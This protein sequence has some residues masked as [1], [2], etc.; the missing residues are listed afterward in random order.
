MRDLKSF[1]LNGTCGFDPHPGHHHFSFPVARLAG[2]DDCGPRTASS[3]HLHNFGSLRFVL[4]R[5]TLFK[6]TNSTR[7]PFEL[8]EQY[9]KFQRGEIVCEWLSI[10]SENEEKYKWWAKR[11]FG[12]TVSVICTRLQAAQNTSSSALD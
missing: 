3:Q 2:D 6:I 1:V 4:A 7:M 8:Y 11:I 9:A 12:G 5:T 10:A